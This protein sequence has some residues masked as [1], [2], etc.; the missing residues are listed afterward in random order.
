MAIAI[1]S[2]RP[3]PAVF[4]RVDSLRGVAGV[5]AEELRGDIL[6]V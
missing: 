4:V 6:N 5:E 1:S 2:L 3:R